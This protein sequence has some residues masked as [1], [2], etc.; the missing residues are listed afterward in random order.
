MYCVGDPMPVISAPQ[1]VD[2]TW[3]NGMGFAIAWPH[4]QDDPFALT[5]ILVIKVGSK[6]ADFSVLSLAESVNSCKWSGDWFLEE[7]TNGFQCCFSSSWDCGRVSLSS[8]SLCSKNVIS[9]LSRC[10][11]I[12]EWKWIFGYAMMP[13]LM[14]WANESG[15]EFRNEW[16]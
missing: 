8:Y 1:L 9:R 3:R 16:N 15:G 7:Q 2:A 13:G 4:R 14:N 10:R 5:G 12:C 11:N 6:E